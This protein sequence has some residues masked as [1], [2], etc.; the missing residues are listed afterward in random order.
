[1]AKNIGTALAKVHAVD[2]IHG[3]LTTSNLMLRE[4]NQSLVY[5]EES[6]V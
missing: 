1:L 6:L 2:V 3:D 5:K 4:S